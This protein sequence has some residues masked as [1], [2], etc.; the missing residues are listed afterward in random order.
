MGNPQGF[1]RFSDI[2]W[3]GGGLSCLSL[4]PHCTS[5]PLARGDVHVAGPSSRCGGRSAHTG[6]GG[7]RGRAR[8]DGPIRAWGGVSAPTPR[9][10]GL[11]HGVCGG[12]RPGEVPVGSA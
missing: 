5:F 6:P 7:P 12:L 3:G 8:A 11:F 2:G 4:H 10:T 9:A 1:A